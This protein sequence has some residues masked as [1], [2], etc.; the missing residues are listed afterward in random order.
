MNA[1]AAKKGSN[2]Y[3]VLWSEVEEIEA[4]ISHYRACNK[5]LEE[6]KVDMEKIR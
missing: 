5:I 2:E 4:A 1:K 3:K 6:A